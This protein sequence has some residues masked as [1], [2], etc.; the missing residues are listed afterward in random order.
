M[1]IYT[2]Y[3][4]NLGRLKD[5]GIE[6]IG[7]ALYPPKWFRGCSVQTCSPTK[8]I[9]FAKN[10]TQEEYVSRYRKEVLSRLDVNGF[11]ETLKSF[12]HGKDVALCC[13]EK[14]SDFCHRHILA[15]WLNENYGLDIQEFGQE[16]QKIVKEEPKAVQ[17]DLGFDF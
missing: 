4:G 15:E 8:S 1:K 2:S 11:L 14:P 9:L 7:I 10:Q 6:P 17:L 5:S 13:Y 3:F 12:S 16:K